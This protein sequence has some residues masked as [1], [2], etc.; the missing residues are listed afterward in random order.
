MILGAVMIVVIFGIVA[1]VFDYGARLKQRRNMQNVADSAALAGA[2]ELDGTAAGQSAAQAKAIE[3]VTKNVSGLSAAPTITFN[4]D[5]TE[6]YV[7]VAKVSESFFLGTLGLGDNNIAAHAR[8]RIAAPLLPGPGVVPLAIDLPTYNNCIDG[9]VCTGVT[10]KE[11]SSNNSVPRNSY[12]LLDLG[13]VGGGANEVCDYLI[14]GSTVSIT[15]P[16]N[17]KQGNVSSLHNCLDDRMTAA[18]HNNCLTLSDVLDSNGALKDRCNPLAGAGKGADSSYPNAQPTAVIVIPVVTDFSGTNCSGAHCVDIVGSGDQLRTFAIFLIDR[19]TVTAI[20]GV[21]PT[22]ANPGN[23]GGKSAN[24]N[25]NGGNSGGGNGQCWITGQFLLT[26]YAPV[27][28]E[29]DL[30]TGEYDPNA[31]LKIVQL[32]D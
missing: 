7:Q 8:A 6:I 25:G 28:T 20:N 15:D 19:T 5:K 27:S 14:G 32:I 12:G 16:D 1:V 31:L 2:Q 23:G 21:G 10:L 13:G 3:Y 30:P 4:S 17:E 11:E 29:F 9:G 18:A 26:H 24:G 22:C